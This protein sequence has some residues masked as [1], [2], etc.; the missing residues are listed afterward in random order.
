MRRVLLLVLVTMLAGPS[1]F[2]A[3]PPVVKA[4]VET[5]GLFDDEEGGNAD[6]DDPAIWVNERDPG[7]SIVVAT[8]KEGGL[9]SYRLDGT[10]I[11]HVPAPPRPGPEHAP[12]RF[13]NVDIVGDLAIVSDRGRDHIRFYQVNGLVDVTAPDVPFVFNSTQ[14]EV[15]EQKT[16][17]GLAAWNSDGATYVLVSRRSTT[18]VALLKVESRGGMYSYRVVRK[19]DLPASF[20]LPNGT[21]WQPCD[22]PGV[23]P[24]VEGMVVD[25]RTGTLYA[26]QEDVGIWRISANLTGRPVLIDKVREFGVPGSYDPA[27]EECVPGKDP[28]FGGKHISADVEGLT[29]HYGR[30]L[31]L[32]SS[33]GDNTFAAYDLPGKYKT[34]FQIKLGDD[35]VQESD[36]AA[37]IGTGLGHRFPHGLLAVQ[38]GDNAGESRE[39]TNF[40]FVRWDD[41]ARQ[42]S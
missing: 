10:Q 20:T 36:G 11:R 5:P 35:L 14:S 15:D 41:V 21:T 19:L 12:G 31:L 33:Q 34:S 7:R 6:A 29:I 3:G 32:A 2:A 4:Q 27:T 1:A 40:K 22:E 38:D 9:H 8:A 42:L 30:N 28:G 13:N 18:Q 17:Y 25:Y 16:A 37:V 39:S 24:Q 23:L 26:G